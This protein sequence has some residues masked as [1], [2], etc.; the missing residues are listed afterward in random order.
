MITTALCLQAKLDMMNGV[1]QPGDTYRLALFT[2]RAVL[3]EDTTRYVSRNETSGA[4]YTKGGFHLTGRRTQL[5]EGV[6]CLTFNDIKQERCTFE[7]SGALV[8]NESRNNAALAVLAFDA[9]KRP[10][11]GLFELEFPLLSP[12]SAVVVIA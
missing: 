7:A 9:L 2:E 3:D 8:Y 1:H 10:S 5:I 6:A 4:G 12:N 11:N